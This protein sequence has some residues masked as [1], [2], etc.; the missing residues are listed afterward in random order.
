MV[1]FPLPR[2]DKDERLEKSLLKYCRLKSGEIWEDS[3]VGHK[4]GCLDATN[5]SDISSLMADEKAKLAIHDPPYNMVAFGIAKS[6]NFIDWCKMW[7]DNSEL[8]MDDNSSFYVW[9]GADQKKH[10]EPFPEFILMMR[11]TP[12]ISKSF[13]TMRNQRGYGTQKNWMSIRQELL[14]YTKGNP[15]FNIES[16]YTDIPKVLK[17]YYKKINGTNTDN[18]ERSKSDKIRAGNVWMDIQQV[19]H[20]REENVNGCYAQKP[21]KSYERIVT[22][23]SSEDD[24]VT[25]F[26]CHAGTTLLVSELFK[27]RCYTIDINPIY[28]EIAIR[29]LE[30]FRE[31]GKL[32]WQ[33]SNPFE[34]DILEDSELMDYLKTEYEFDF[35]KIINKKR[36]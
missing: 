32:G 11:E 19:F 33:A 26:F 31:H 15:V 4:I 27:R 16:V 1:Q 23:S 2:L 8:T 24:L 25:D 12:F 36:K 3:Q 30:R 13:I 14:Y 9:L 35:D 6:E 22:A 20:L 7:V 21:L 10:F 18:F 28:C 17:G 5:S 29:R 34:N